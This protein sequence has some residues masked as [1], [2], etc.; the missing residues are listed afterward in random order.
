[1]DFS[2]RKIAYY[3]PYVGYLYIIAPSAIYHS[4]GFWVMRFLSAILLFLDTRVKI[5]LSETIKKIK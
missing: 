4:Y 3:L 1:M 2:C 5:D